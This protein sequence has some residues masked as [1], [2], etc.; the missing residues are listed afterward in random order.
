MALEICTKGALSVVSL[1]T[2]NGF[3]CYTSVLQQSVQTTAFLPLTA[4]GI[5][6]PAKHSFI[7]QQHM[8][9]GLCKEATKA[10]SCLHLFGLLLAHTTCVVGLWLV[11]ITW[12]CSALSFQPAAV[13]KRHAR[14]LKQ[15]QPRLEPVS[16]RSDWS[17]RRQMLTH[18]QR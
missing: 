13:E 9:G 8:L 11:F 2:A 15:M 18:A 16:G 5:D 7:S 1:A 4:R 12:L 3:E 17:G 10:N 14:E 6:E